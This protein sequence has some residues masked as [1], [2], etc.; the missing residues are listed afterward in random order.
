MTFHLPFGALNFQTES[1]HGH[2]Q[3]KKTLKI[4]TH[5]I[6]NITLHLPLEL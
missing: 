1:L 2:S 4:A 6:C 3:L 5:I